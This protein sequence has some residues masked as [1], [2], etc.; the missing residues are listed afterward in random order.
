MK[1]LILLAMLAI[2]L[3]AGAQAIDMSHGGPVDV[4][5][6]DGLEYDQNAM[7]VTANGN[8]RA[9]RGDVTVRADQLI[10]HL[11]KKAGATAPNPAAPHTPQSAADQAENGGN[12]IYRLEAIGH[13]F[14]D[15]PTDHA[16]GADHGIYDIDQAV[17][18]LTGPALKLTT[19]QEV[20][21][22]RDTL[23]Y[24]SQRHMAV[25]RGHA[26][27]VATDG[28]RIAGD[29]LVAYTTDPQSSTPH[30]KPVQNASASA[31]TDPFGASG[32]LQRVEAFGHVVIQ[33]ATEIV[34]GDRGVYMP[35][36]GIARLIGHVHITRGLNQLN[37]EEA[38]VNMKTGISTLQERPGARV[39]G[40]VVPNSDNSDPQGASKTTKP[41]KPAP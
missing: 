39:E 17:L 6:L 16:E 19:P 29:T 35:D 33:T 3:R 31:G 36:T 8:A 4:T 28:R 25:A 1:K 18:I 5:A 12:E 22:A 41:A 20:I 30:P 9:V 32:K 13:V 10:A 7:T 34:T 37:G 11:R 38:L 14:I 15:T 27:V 26:L 2:P 24:W 40:L 23:E 21:T